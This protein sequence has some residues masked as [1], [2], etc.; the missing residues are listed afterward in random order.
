MATLVD[1]LRGR[2]GASLRTL[3]AG[4]AEPREQPADGGLFGP[5]SATWF[6]HSDA[7]MLVG[8]VRALL[9]QTLH[10]P[11]M[12]GVADHSSYE[13][14]PLGRLQRTGK[15]LGTTT[16]G[17]VEEAQAAIATVRRI[18]SHVRGMTPDGHPYS[19]TD[20]HLLKWVHI[21]E[22]DS[23]LEAKR[24]FGSGQIDADTADSY[25]REMAI[26]GE[27]LGVTEAPLNVAELKDALDSYRPELKL[28]GQSR[29]A[30]RFIAMPPL[31]LAMR[32]PYA[33]LLG[34]AVSSLPRWARRKL[35]LPRLPITETL[36]VQP[37]ALTLVR[38]LDWSMAAA[39]TGQP[40]DT[41]G[42]L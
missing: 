27:G 35:W 28:N 34:G 5:D 19:A 26:V 16:F 42:N 12:A 40:E 39:R 30:L 36:A 15:F 25:V 31:Q 8:G 32:G 24:R 10:A 33:V 14:D 29:R 6:V 7:A 21:T 37:A 9:L 41:N 4:D 18:H 1:Q 3:V 38:L 20:P 23:F 2:I 11:T 22:V 13:S 17:T